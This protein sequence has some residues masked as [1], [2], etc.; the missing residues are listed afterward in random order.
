M[1]FVTVKDRTSGV[2]SSSSWM[3]LS[4]QSCAVHPQGQAKWQAVNGPHVLGKLHTSQQRTCVVRH[5]GKLLHQVDSAVEQLV[6]EHTD[7]D[8][9]V[10]VDAT[11]HSTAHASA[12]HADAGNHTTTRQAVTR[13]APLRFARQWRWHSTST[14]MQSR[15]RQGRRSLVPRTEGSPATRRQPPGR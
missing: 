10:G 6:V 15:H 8:H 12:T 2:N 7:V 9:A 13:C 11:L 5:V 3:T 14:S 1:C 4:K